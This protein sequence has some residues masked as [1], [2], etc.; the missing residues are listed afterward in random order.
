MVIRCH[1]L[2]LIAM[3]MRGSESQPDEP[4]DVTDCLAN[5]L[6]RMKM[7]IASQEEIEGLI[8]QRTSVGKRGRNR[9]GR[10]AC[11]FAGCEAIC[12]VKIEGNIVLEKDMGQAF[13]L[14]ESCSVMKLLVM[15][16]EDS[17]TGS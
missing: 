2:I 9:Y 14:L 12:N 16:E 13:A 17:P 4:L 15:Q 6:G 8:E 7:G 5:D 1:V 3:H 10:L 11:E